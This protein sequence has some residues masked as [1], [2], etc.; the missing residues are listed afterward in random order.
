MAVTKKQVNV[1]GKNTAYV[2]ESERSISIG[3]KKCQ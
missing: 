2:L 3:G 1:Y